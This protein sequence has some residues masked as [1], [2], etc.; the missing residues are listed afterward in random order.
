MSQLSP[1][2]EVALLRA[3]VGEILSIDDEAGQTPG[4]VA[5]EDAFEGRP[6]RRWLQIKDRIR[7]LSSAQNW[8]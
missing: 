5:V 8:T 6:L 2:Q 4:C 7:A 1:E 3:T